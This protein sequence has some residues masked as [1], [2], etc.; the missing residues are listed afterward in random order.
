[1]DSMIGLEP[2][3]WLE[4]RV[5]KRNESLKDPTDEA[6]QMRLDAYKFASCVV[7]V[8][9]TSRYTMLMMCNHLPHVNPMK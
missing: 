9:T 5:T 6:Y 7:I 3:L 1:M 8:A 2:K 4:V